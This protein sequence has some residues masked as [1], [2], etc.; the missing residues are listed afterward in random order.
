MWSRLTPTYKQIRPCRSE[1]QHH[2]WQWS[3]TNLH[4]SL[5]ICDTPLFIIPQE[6]LT[7]ARGQSCSGG[8]Q[9]LVRTDTHAA[10]D[11]RWLVIWK[12]GWMR[13]AGGEQATVIRISTRN[14]TTSPRLW[15][16][17]GE[18]EEEEHKNVGSGGGVKRHVPRII[19]YGGTRKRKCQQI[20]VVP[21][22]LQMTQN[23]SKPG[24]L[25]NV[26]GYVPSAR[27]RK[28]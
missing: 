25:L 4:W 19:S 16:G 10:S 15:E 24:F 22:V 3:L 14:W 20:G 26:L 21:F 2:P 1:R 8:S 5:K 12:K 27:I 11:R 23:D 13:G 7:W 9:K 17:G 28:T 18:E 6:W